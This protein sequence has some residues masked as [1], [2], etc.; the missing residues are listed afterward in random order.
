M[1]LRRL[2]LALGAV[3][4]PGL[5]ALAFFLRAPVLV[6]T[7]APFVPLYGMQRI[8]LQQF[9]SSLIL[10]RRVKP[11][12]VADGAGADVVLFAVGEASRRPYCVLFPFRF[13]DSAGRY[14][15]QSPEIPVLLMENRGSKTGAGAPDQAS[16]NDIYII[17]TDVQ[18]DFYRAGRC[19]AVLAAGKTGAAVVFLGQNLQTEGEAAFMSGFSETETGVSPLF[20]S[21]LSYFS[22]VSDVS[23]AVLAGAGMEYFDQ[24]RT[25][26]LILFSW[27]NPAQTSREVSVIFDDSPW[28]LTVPAVRMVSRQQSGGKVPSKVVILSAKIA[29]KGILRKLKRAAAGLREGE[30]NFS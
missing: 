12:M 9:R 7:D 6:I 8:K 19:A 17:K 22:G 2:I 20:F 24:N 21:Q 18:T 14:R 13:A 27:L 25:A 3:L 10:F 11:V 4:L 15:Q 29:D 5:L 26:P 1:K 23:C 30:Q 16:S 28:T